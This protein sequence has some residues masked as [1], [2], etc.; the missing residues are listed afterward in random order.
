LP[1]VDFKCTLISFFLP[2]P[3]ALPS[4]EAAWLRALPAEASVRIHVGSSQWDNEEISRF[5]PRVREFPNLYVQI[6]SPAAITDDGLK[7]LLDVRD[8]KG[9]QLSGLK[10]SDEGVRR[11][12]EFPRLEYL[13]FHGIPV[14]DKT[15]E[16]LV[17]AGKCET[18][19]LH[20]TA[21]D[22]ACLPTVLKNT[23][24]AFLWWWGSQLTDDDLQKLT[25]LKKL[26]IVSLS[27]GAFTNEGI[28]H[29]RALPILRD[30]GL[31]DNAHID[32]TVFDYFREMDSLTAIGLGGVKITDAGLEKAKMLPRL[33]RFG[34][35]RTKVTAE[36]VAKL[37]AALP[38]LLVEWDGDG[39]K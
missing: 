4:K 8:L 15:V 7:A 23:S 13:A 32:D 25:A 24:L 38:K 39:K 16:L 1:K 28:R 12:Q 29:L 33:E 22:G 14:T 27:G 5:I 3:D 37:R 19:V 36:G 11:L 17:S 10:V 31:T 21:A 2:S 9:C 18:L 35:E 20:Y 30:L 26:E 6:Q 34:L